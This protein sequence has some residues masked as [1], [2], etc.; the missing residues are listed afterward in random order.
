MDVDSR[1]NEAK[2]DMKDI[3]LQIEVRLS[4]CA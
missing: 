4:A 1:K 3:E 2:N